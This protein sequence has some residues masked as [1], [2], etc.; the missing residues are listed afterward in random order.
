MT[1][2]LVGDQAG[3]GQARVAD[4]AAAVFLAHEERGPPQLGAAAPVGRVVADRVVTESPQRVRRHLL[5]QEAVGG[6]AEELLIFAQVQEHW[7]P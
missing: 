2:E 1:A 7:A 4:G 5:G 3:V 6:L